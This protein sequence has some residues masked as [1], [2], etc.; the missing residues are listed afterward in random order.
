VADANPAAK[1]VRPTVTGPNPAAGAANPIVGG[2][3]PTATFPNP[4]AGGAPPAVTFPP[5]MTGF[6]PPVVGGAPLTIGFAPLFVKNKP[7]SPKTPVLAA[8]NVVPPTLGHNNKLSEELPRSGAPTT[9]K[10]THTKY[11]KKQLVPAG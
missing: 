8:W 11:E 1:G 4:T 3:N 2:A 6:A 10:Q 7:F 5:P 9:V